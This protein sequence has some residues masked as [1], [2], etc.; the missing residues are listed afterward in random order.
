MVLPSLVPA[1]PGFVLEGCEFDA[2]SLLP[3]LDLALYTNGTDVYNRHA[4]SAQ[5]Q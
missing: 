3:F 2:R 5:V 4:G 1:Q